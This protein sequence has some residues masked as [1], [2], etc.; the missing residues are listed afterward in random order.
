[1]TTTGGTRT[2][3]VSTSLAPSGGSSGARGMRGPYSRP[4]RAQ[5]DDVDDVG[6][7]QH[8]ARDE[9]AEQDVA[10][11]GVGDRADDDGEHRR[12]DDGAE[13]AAGADRA[14]DQA[15]GVVVLQHGRDREQA[16]HRLGGAD[17]AAGRREDHAHDDGADRQAAGNASRPH[18]DGIE[19]A[20][21][22]ARRLEHGAHEDEERHGGQHLRRRHLLDLLDELVLE[23]LVAEGVEPE[24]HRQRHH[25]QRHG[26]AGQDRGD[27]GREHPERGHQ[28]IFL[29]CGMRR[30]RRD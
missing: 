2:L 8:E 6:D 9:H 14:A 12:R 17:D 16:D 1:M 25:G 13:R 3:A 30:G 29:G 10:D 5:S 27:E 15:L 7:R 11:R 22:D 21:G 18:V 28:A 19:Q 20:R 4:Q 23:A 24:H 26:E